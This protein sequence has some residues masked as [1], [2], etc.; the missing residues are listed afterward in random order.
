[1]MENKKLKDILGYLF[2]AACMILLV[3][4][5]VKL[6]IYDCII[7]NKLYDDNDIV[8]RYHRF[9]NIVTIDNDTDEMVYM[10]YL[11][12]RA[13]KNAT[14]DKYASDIEY[15]GRRSEVY[16]IEPNS[17]FAEF[18]SIFDDAY[19]FVIYNE[20]DLYEAVGFNKLEWF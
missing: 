17:K 5:G 8:V 12:G 19:V 4:T 2:V 6:V 16:E 15:Y 3:V 10:H 14:G 7:G 13:R 1:M 11:K 20:N 9:V 18:T